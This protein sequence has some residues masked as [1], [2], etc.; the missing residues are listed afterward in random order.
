[1]PEAFLHASGISWPH[2]IKL[3]MEG[4]LSRER[5]RRHIVRSAE[6]RE[7]VIQRVL[8]RY[9]DAGQLQT[10]AVPVPFEQV[11]FANGSVEQASW[12]DSRRVLIVGSGARR[13]DSN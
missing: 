9:V 3:E 1:M 13:R 8:V 7:K 12:S 10:P 6:R 2:S 11:V 4:D 5:P